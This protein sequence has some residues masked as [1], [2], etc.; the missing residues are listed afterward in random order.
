MKTSFGN[1]FLASIAIV[2][3]SFTAALSAQIVVSGETNSDTG[4]TVSSTDLLQTNLAS[5]TDSIS[6]NTTE[7]N[8]IGGSVALLNN[9]SFG[10]AGASG[11]ICI[12][13]GSVTYDLNTPGA[14]PGYDI[15]AVNVYTGWNDDGRDGQN[16][17]VSYSTVGN[18]GTFID[19]ATATQDGA[20]KFESTSI[21]QGTAPNLLATGVKAI[22]ITFNGQ[23][24]GGVGYKEIDV[25]GST[26]FPTPRNLTWSNGATTDAWNT[27]DANWT[28]FIWDNARPDHAIFGSTGGTVN[29]ATITAGSVNVGN[30]GSNFTSVTLTGGSLSASSLT[31][32][33]FANNGGN[34]G[35][36]PTLSLDADVTISGDAAV[37]RA[38]LAVTSGNITA[39]RIISA[40]ASADWGRLVVSGGTL[41]ATNG[42]DGSVNTTA[43]FAIDLNGGE[44]RT[45]SIRV[46]DREQGPNNSA[47]LTFNGGTLKAT[48]ADNADFITTYGGGQNTFVASGGAIIDT[49]GLNIGILVNLLDAG[50]GGGLTKQGA[51]TLTLSG[52]YSYS[53]ATYVEAGTLALTTAT[54]NDNAVVDIAST[55]VINLPVG[56]TDTVADFL[57]NGVSQGPGT[58]NSANT[59]GRITGGSLVVPAVDPFQA[60]IDPFNVDPETAEGDPDKDGIANLLEYVL[61]GGDPSASNPGIL[62]TL[63]ASGVNF[64][65][66]Y[67]RRT[68][69]TGTTQVFQYSPDLGVTPW[70]GLTIPGGSGVTVTD[71]GGG[72]EQVEITVPKDANTKLFGRLLVTKP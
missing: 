15:S 67:S 69:A 58:W 46:A 55:A 34:Y 21:T 53:G 51:G 28:G 11:G 61:Q 25:I 6:V 19:I 4:F 31:V 30:T 49:N 44:L 68:A 42:V 52:T 37:G 7:N 26:P 10:A 9:G 3:A 39:N 35:S 20:G 14:S 13:G 36:N 71:L 64:V 40:P 50:G 70:I 54:L 27:T 16:Y 60:W 41:T 43:T 22:R 65:F 38:N 45:P 72:I 12:N 5:T 56:S 57:I 33:G 62:P 32:Q 2:F 29:L 63:N 18:P 66:T 23:E 17:T 8:A 1:R 24:N 47:W 48:G 59:G